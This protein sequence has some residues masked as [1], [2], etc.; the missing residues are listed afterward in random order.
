MFAKWGTETL[1]Y[2]K[3]EKSTSAEYNYVLKLYAKYISFIMLTLKLFIQ[4]HCSI[5]SYT[6]YLLSFSSNIQWAFY[7]NK[8]AFIV[9]HWVSNMDELIHKSWALHQWFSS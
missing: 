1:E 4:S 5:K 9:V 6:M 2:V 7:H 3:K 8:T